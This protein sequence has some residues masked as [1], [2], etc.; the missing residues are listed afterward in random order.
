MAYRESASSLIRLTRRAA[1]STALKNVFPV[2]ETHGRKLVLRSD[3]DLDE[4]KP[5]QRWSLEVADTVLFRWKSG[6]DEITYCSIGKGDPTLIEFWFTHILLPLYLTIEK[7]CHFLHASAVKFGD[8]AVLFI[9][10]SM[11]GKSTMANFLAEQ[12]HAFMADDKVLVTESDGVYFAAPSHPFSRPNRGWET[13]GT[14]VEPFEDRELP[15]AA[16]FELKDGQK[17]QSRRLQGA[18]SFS[19]LAPHHL[20]ELPYRRANRL[21]WLAA[22]ASIVDVVRLERPWGLQ[23]MPAIRQSVASHLGSL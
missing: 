22:L 7:R 6:L 9:A 13:L 12:G 4:P 3:G 21:G 18:E 15:I 11:S 19:A 14:V 23:H 1:E 16:I 10:P 17:V 20:L 5:A 2:S 8:A